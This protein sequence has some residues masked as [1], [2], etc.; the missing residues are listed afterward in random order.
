[1]SSLAPPLVFP[2]LFD[3]DPGHRSWP[4]PPFAWRHVDPPAVDRRQPCRIETDE[5]LTCEGELLAFD[6]GAGRLAW[7][8]SAGSSREELP[9]DR[10]RRLT[11][12]APLVALDADRS[13]RQS[14][15]GAVR[16][17]ELAGHP[18]NSVLPLAEQERGYTIEP[19]RTGRVLSGRSVGIVER[20]E[21]LFLF[22]PTDDD[23][24]LLR[25]FVPRSVDD[26]VVTLGRTALETA[27]QGWADS[28]AALLQQIETLRRRP[29]P[30][31]GVATQS[32]GLLTAAQVERWLTDTTDDRPLGRVLVDRGL[33]SHAQL[34]AVIAHKM[35]CPVADL[36]RFAP[37]PAALTELPSRAAWTQRA[38]PLCIAQ[39][40]L[41]IASDRILDDDRRRALQSYTRL[42]LAPVLA[43]TSHLSEAFRDLG[44]GVGSSFGA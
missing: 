23:A 35:G 15:L 24:A 11:L 10:C 39:D 38:L 21:G 4:Q 18:V 16:P 27:M 44:T 6:L 30:P 22:E 36:T 8:A 25:V 7:R 2:P 43:R 32:L 31:L 41:Y 34:Q 3:L 13:R 9:F 1:M 20:P 37:Q 12:L 17:I 42:S 14:L 29:V 33:L 26:S 40:R 28:P 19:R 5:G